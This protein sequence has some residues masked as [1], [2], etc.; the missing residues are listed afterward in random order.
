M[1]VKIP[2]ALESWRWAVIREVEDEEDRFIALVS[3][4]LLPHISVQINVK[5]GFHFDVK[6]SYLLVL[7]NETA[8]TPWLLAHTNK[9]EYLAASV[10]LSVKW[11]Y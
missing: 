5:E 2:C 8:S 7:Y 1:I 6:L 4:F 3:T 9:T 11:E 10:F